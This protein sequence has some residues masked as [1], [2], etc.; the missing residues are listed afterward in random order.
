MYDLIGKYYDIKSDI[1]SINPKFKIISLLLFCILTLIVN[2]VTFSIILLLFSLILL[3]LT[4]V[5]Y[6]LYLMRSIPSF[7]FV[8]SLLIIQI[9]FNIN[10]INIAIKI[11][12][13]SIYYS[14]YIY[15]TK[16]IDTNKGLFEI[17]KFLDIKDYRASLICLIL[18][19]FIS[20]VYIEYYNTRKIRINREINY[21]N[22]FI[23]FKYSIIK[24]K[25]RIRTI[26]NIFKLKSFNYS[27]LEKND[28]LIGITVLTSHL[29]LFVV[30][31]FGKI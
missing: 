3:V 30:Y 31:F 8:I 2:N 1:H 12:S 19:H 15:T 13:F 6:K 4:K 27:Y 21:S 17:F 10:T 18:I 28:F 11:V 29:M 7:L 23:T 14:S 9:I 22:P 16:M 20:I 5:P 26:T 24:I 25:Y